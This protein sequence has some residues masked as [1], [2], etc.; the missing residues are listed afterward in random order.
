MVDVEKISMKYSWKVLREVSSGKSSF[1]DLMAS[2]FKTKPGIS[3]KTLSD[4][5]RELEGEGLIKRDLIA[6]RPP[7]S[8][9][10][11]TRK[12]EEALK[13]LNKLEKL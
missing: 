12:G 11:I 7:R 6:S 2:L 13:L 8:N 3:T 5:L 10:T 9:Y 1:K 4:R